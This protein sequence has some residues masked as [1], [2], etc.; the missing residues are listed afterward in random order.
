MQHKEPWQVQALC[1]LAFP[2]SVFW[3]VFSP[4]AAEKLSLCLAW[5]AKTS[6]NF[7]N[8][9]HQLPH[10]S[11]MSLPPTCFH[12]DWMCALYNWTNTADRDMVV[13]SLE[14][15]YYCCLSKTITLTKPCGMSEDIQTVAGTSKWYGCHLQSRIIV[16][17]WAQLH[18]WQS[19]QVPEGHDDRR[20]ASWWYQ[21]LP[22][23][24][25]IPQD[26]VRACGTAAFIS[27]AH[28]G[29]WDYSC[30]RKW[31]SLGIDQTGSQGRRCNT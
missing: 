22:I 8:V 28:Y 14:C 23:C 9:M 12:T 20:T 6:G 4:L 21:H 10:T 29:S 31:N 30:E 25:C 16:Q 26:I 19:G 15:T 13:V 17:V 2:F 5:L 7:L 24:L 27:S 1:T 18:C 11:N 3:S